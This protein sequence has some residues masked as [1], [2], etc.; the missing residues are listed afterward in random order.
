M[1]IFL[2]LAPFILQMMGVAEKFFS[3]K[4]K[5]GA[6]KKEMVMGATQVVVDSMQ[7]IST[8]GQK[9]TWDQLEAPVSALVDGACEVAFKNPELK[10]RD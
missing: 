9:E 3:H 8:G 6:D 2:K 10:T 4:E 7:A 1:N 5:S